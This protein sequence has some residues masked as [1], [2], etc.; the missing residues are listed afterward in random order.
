MNVEKKTIFL[1]VILFCIIIY[2]AV[3]TYGLIVDQ[4]DDTVFMIEE[5]ETAIYIMIQNNITPKKIVFFSTFMF[6][7]LSYFYY[8]YMP[9]P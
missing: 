6:N 5:G 9:S 3:S 8:L 1:G 2:I 4:F 7:T